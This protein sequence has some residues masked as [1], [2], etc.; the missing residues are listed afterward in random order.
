MP[1]DRYGIYLKEFEQ[2]LIAINLRH[3][4][5][6][7]GVGKRVEAIVRQCIS[8]HAISLDQ[9]ERQHHQLVAAFLLENDALLEKE[10]EKLKEWESNR[11]TEL[12]PELNEQV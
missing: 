1:R 7:M 11:L 8:L 10:M 3:A 4:A 2:K 6:N 9:L 12:F 5:R